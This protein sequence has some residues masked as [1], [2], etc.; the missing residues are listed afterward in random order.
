MPP[1]VENRTALSE[2]QVREFRKTCAAI[3]KRPWMMETA[4]TYLSQ[5]V[6]A[7]QNGFSESWVLPKITWVFNPPLS[8]DTMPLPSGIME[9]QLLSVKKQPFV[10]TYMFAVAVPISAQCGILFAVPTVLY[11]PRQSVGIKS[12]IICQ[13]C[14]KFVRSAWGICINLV[15]CISEVTFTTLIGHLALCVWVRC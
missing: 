7:N 13:N 8:F 3:R 6:D 5:W 15:C 14:T 1:L 11:A 10:S 12:P 9:G 4:A 2:R